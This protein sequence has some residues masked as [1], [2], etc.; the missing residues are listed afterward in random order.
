[1]GKINMTYTR[2]YHR[3]MEKNKPQLYATNRCLSNNFEGKGA[4]KL[5]YMLFN[6]I[7]IK[8]PNLQAGQ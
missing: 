2:E 7:C 5:K 1:M 6:S 3:T 8:F 4:D